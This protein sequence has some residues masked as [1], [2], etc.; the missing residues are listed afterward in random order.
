MKTH[1]ESRDFLYDGSQ[2]ASLFAYQTWGLMGTSLVSWTGPCDITIHMVDAEDQRAKDL[3]CGSKMVHFIAEIFDAD[4]LSAVSFQRLMAAMIKDYLETQAPSVKQ[5][6]WL[7][8]G[9][10]IYRVVDGK[11]KKLSISIATKSPVST[12]I[13]FAVNVSNEGTPVPTCALDD[14]QIESETFAKAI[15]A[16]VAREFQGVREATYKVHPVG[17][18]NPAR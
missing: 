17:S 18:Y 10:D 3:I 14:F 6:I 13:H 7:R 15:L 11:R 8:E 1:F 5:E 4:L 12:L 16:L 9:D 2:L